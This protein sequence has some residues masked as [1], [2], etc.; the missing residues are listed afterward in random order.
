MI[1]KLPE[2]EMKKSRNSWELMG[3]VRSEL[4]GAT[5]LL[6]IVAAFA[7]ADKWLEISGHPIN[8]TDALVWFAVFMLVMFGHLV[9]NCAEAILV[10]ITER[11]AR[12]R[13]ISSSE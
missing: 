13:A 4:R 1:Q 11:P 9:A 2:D 12:S 3:E 7:L 8:N 10:A 5:I 6:I